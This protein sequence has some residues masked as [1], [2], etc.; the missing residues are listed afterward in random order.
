MGADEE[1]LFPFSEESKALGPDIETLRNVAA[2]VL[3]ESATSL[4][5]PGRRDLGTDG[6]GI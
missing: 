5:S 3:I 4:T 6:D 2:A 1:P